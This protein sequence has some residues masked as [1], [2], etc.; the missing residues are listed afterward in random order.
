MSSIKSWF[1]ASSLVAVLLAAPLSAATLYFDF[2]DA[3]SPSAGSNYNDVTVNGN[4]QPIVLANTFDSTGAGTGIGLTASGFFPGSNQDGSQTPGGAAAATFIASATR[5]NAFTHVGAFGGQ[6]TN[7]EGLLVF[8]GLDNST[9]YD[10]TF[11]A[12]RM[13]VTDIRET[14][15]TVTGSNSASAALNASNN[16]ENI[17]AVSGILPNAGS[18]SITVEAGPNNN[19]GGT[20]ATATKF[21]Y[22]GAL[23]VSTAIPEPA[24]FGLLSLS[25]LGLVFRRRVAK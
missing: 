5:D 2:G 15:Y 14:L 11:F 7:P 3:A 10:F 8:T 13:N 19:N 23:R 24:T 9:A 4:P 21:A 12:S 20:S 1:L 6:E 18:I 22:L 16:T 17:A 25:A